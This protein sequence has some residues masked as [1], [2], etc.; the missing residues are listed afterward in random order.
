MRA[1][2]L[3]RVALNWLFEPADERIGTLLREHP[4]VDVLQMLCDPA[5]AELR[6]EIAARLPKLDPKG[7][8]ARA[9]EVGARFL[10]PGDDEWPPSLADLA[11]AAPIQGDQG[12]PIGLWVRGPL[13]LNEL[14][15][16]VAVVGSR[17]ASSYG[18]DV[19]SQ[20]AAELA[21]D[22]CVVVSGG[23]VGID[24]AAHMGALAVRRPTVAVL[25][26]GV[27]RAY[28]QANSALLD[29]IA[30]QGAV[31]SESPPGSAPMKHRFLTRNRV[32]AG[33]SCGTVVVEA[34]VRSGALNTANWTDQ[35]SRPVMAVPGPITSAVSEGTH[36]LLRRGAAVV[37]SGPH[38]RELID[39]SGSSTMPDPREQETSVDRMS[40][41]VRRI[42]DA[43][44]K[45]RP[46]PSASIARVAGLG[47]LDVV[48]A[49]NNLQRLG[50]VE[51]RPD[52]WIQAG[53]TAA[54]PDTLDVGDLTAP[55]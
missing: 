24:A 9:D 23:A 20:L 36:E 41:T 28:P 29:R 43:T 54:D 2:R 5:R 35:L 42:L 45:T 21:L 27:D 33:L 18:T 12:E 10:I 40:K 55:L 7:L 25:A 31:V 1:E 22:G 49:L 26:C 39:P 48:A 47:L 11:E 13:R 53:R 34:A 4:A 14:T 38:V 3:A 8:L 15:Q 50:A 16:A 46:A 17:S 52:G 30:V 32:I 37:F 51:L 44:P 6:E 19:A